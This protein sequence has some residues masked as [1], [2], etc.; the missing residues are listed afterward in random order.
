MGIVTH[1]EFCLQGLAE[2]HDAGFIHLDLKP[3]NVFITFDGRLKIGDFGLALPWPADSGVD[4]EGDREYIGP[5]ILEGRFDKPADVFSLGLITLEMACNVVLPENGPTWIALRSGDLSDVPSLT[6]SATSG[7]PGDPISSDPAFA[8]HA[9]ELGNNFGW[10]EYPQLKEPPKF[11]TD[12]TDST[13]L[14]Q[15]VKWMLSP[16]PADRPSVHQLLTSEALQWI[17][18][19]RMAGA[20]VFEGVWGPADHVIVP[21]LGDVDTEMTDV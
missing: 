15:I 8:V 6:S 16:V 9:G 20:I 10:P 17:A 12:I 3:A 18:G 19:R 2:I 4:A 14:D 7:I 11:M 21:T 13:S 1:L 5:E